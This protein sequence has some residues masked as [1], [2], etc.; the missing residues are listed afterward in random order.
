ML[1]DSSNVYVDGHSLFF[2]IGFI[3]NTFITVSTKNN[4]IS[5]KIFVSNNQV[6]ETGAYV[7]G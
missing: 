4:W 6:G 1:V 7:L 5:F 2:A 3:Q